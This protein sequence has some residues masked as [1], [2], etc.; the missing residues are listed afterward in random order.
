[1]I[2]KMSLSNSTLSTTASGTFLSILPNIHS[3]D[4]LKTVLLATIG[5]VVSF[6]LSLLFRYLTKKR[7]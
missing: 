4:V 5:A 2:I 6:V 7:A 1:M 3:E